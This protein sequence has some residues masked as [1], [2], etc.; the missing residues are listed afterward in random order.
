MIP[1]I[2]DHANLTDASLTL[3]AKKTS[4][5]LAR[6]T[7]ESK[8]IDVLIKLRSLQLESAWFV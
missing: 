2:R 3:E 6:D 7:V 5:P 1:V 4:L 8:T